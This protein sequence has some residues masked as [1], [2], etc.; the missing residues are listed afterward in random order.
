MWTQLKPGSWRVGDD[1]SPKAGQ[2]ILRHLNI[3]K[4]A[5]F[6]EAQYFTFAMNAI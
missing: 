6:A 3:V 4:R 5:T 2:E 1:R